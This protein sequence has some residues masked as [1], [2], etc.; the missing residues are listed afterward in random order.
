[1]GSD[2]GSPAT[3]EGGER[4]KGRDVIKEEDNRRQKRKEDA[5]RKK[6]RERERQERS[7]NDNVNRRGFVSSGQYV[8]R[9]YRTRIECDGI[10]KYLTESTSNGKISF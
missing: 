3:R 7:T 2:T 1:M 10:G 6:E 5:E 9:Q 8:Y 4:R